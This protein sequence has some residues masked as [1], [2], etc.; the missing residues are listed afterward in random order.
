MSMKYKYA[1]CALLVLLLL[2]DLQTFPCEATENNEATLV[3]GGDIC[4]GDVVGYFADKTCDYKRP[5]QRI[6]PYLEDAD[7]T[8]VNLETVLWTGRTPPPNKYLP[9]KSVKHWSKAKSVEG[10]KYAGIDI[11]SLANNHALDYGE[12][13]INSTLKMLNK[14]G[15]KYIGLVEA[16]K[17]KQS[18]VIKTINGVKAGFLAYCYYS[19]GCLYG[20]DFVHTKQ[21]WYNKEIVSNE[22]QQLR[23]KVDY[24]VVM[25]HWGFEYISVPPSRVKTVAMELKKLGVN[26]TE[27]IESAFDVSKYTKQMR[28]TSNPTQF[29]F[30]LKFKISRTKILEASYLQYGIRDEPETHCLQPTPLTGKWEEVCGKFDLNCFDLT[31]TSI[32]SKHSLHECLP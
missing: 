2:I 17:Q 25:M 31:E 18:P 28:E 4:L 15:I 14:S 27:L 29:S 24:L 7:L 3:F 32:A 9:E 1:S 6:K 8:I 13:G 16:G 22:V 19:E 23:R 12:K 21:A 10:L 26:L 11:V 30:L 20:R 5:F